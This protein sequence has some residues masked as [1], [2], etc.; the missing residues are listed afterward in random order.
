M[1]AYNVEENGVYAVIFNPSIAID[2]SEKEC[3]YFC[4]YQKEIWIIIGV[5]CFLLVF[6]GVICFSYEKLWAKY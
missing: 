6:F 4:E 1:L 3:D 5:L 2:N